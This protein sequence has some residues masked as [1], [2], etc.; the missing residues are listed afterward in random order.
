MRKDWMC[1]AVLAA[2]AACAHAQETTWQFAYQGFIDTATG[3]FLA[4][5]R[6]TGSFS[7]ADGNH[8]GVISAD[9]L[10]ML[11]TYNQTYI[12]PGGNGCVADPSPYLGCGVVR[13]TYALNGNLDFAVGYSGTDEFE[14]GW[15]G[16]VNTGVSFGS[17]RY[18]PFTS[19]E[20]RFAWTAETTFTI[21]P[22]PPVPEPSAMLL[23]PAGLAVVALASRRR[24]NVSL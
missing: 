18:G 9:E 20:E 19:W 17:G 15:Y 8:D 6:L 1:A 2:G 4:E 23:L 3:E 14:S 21:S 13:F 22:P 12:A 7:G 10:T 24:R 16:G 5:E 11:S